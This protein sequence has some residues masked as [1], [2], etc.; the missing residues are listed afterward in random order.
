MPSMIADAGWFAS[1]PPFLL[2]LALVLEPILGEARGPLNRLPHPVRVFGWLIAGLDRSLN[3]PERRDRTRR[4]LGVVALM[5]TAGSAIVLGIAV[6]ALAAAVPFGWLLALALVIALLAQRSLYRHVA[7][8]ATALSVGGLDAGRDAVARI[9]GRDVAELDIPGV[10]RA[11]IESLAE[12]FS[13]AVVAP[14]FWYGLL[15]LPGILA[16]K[17]VNT[18]DSMIGHLDDRHRAFGWASARLDDGLNWLP[19]RLSGAY[20]ALAAAAVENASPGRAWR[21]MVR[22]A[23]K[24]RSPNAGWPEAAMAGALGLALAGPRR[25]GDRIVD[26]PWLGDAGMSA[27]PAD[28]GRALSMFTVACLIN[29]A[30][31]TVVAALRWAFA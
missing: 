29:G 25:Y 7:Q 24:H 5:L 16:Y 26:D 8:V 19:A 31:V 15:G 6:E 27:A 12:N 20:V 18:L 1:T 17:S 22:D 11:A 14:C 23:G 9:V 2:L 10:V 4:L 21:V 13:D 3:R 28:I 30:A